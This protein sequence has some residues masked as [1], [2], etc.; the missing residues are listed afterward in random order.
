MDENGGPG[1]VGQQKGKLRMR[2]SLGRENWFDSTAGSDQWEL[3]E[4]HFLLRR[5]NGLMCKK[6]EMSPCLTPGSFWSPG[7]NRP[8]QMTAFCV[9]TAHTE[10]KY[11]R[12]PVQDD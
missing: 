4:L 6:K 10:G 12:H 9:H 8:R 2:E 7:T 11:H 3:S 1:T 5:Q